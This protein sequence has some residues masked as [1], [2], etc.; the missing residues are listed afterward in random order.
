MDIS[1]DL[2]LG[3]QLCVLVDRGRSRSQPT[4]SSCGLS[5]SFGLAAVGTANPSKSL[6]HSSLGSSGPEIDSWGNKCNL[7]LPVVSPRLKPQGKCVR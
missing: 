7:F 6:S 3:G 4:S 1:Q 2:N 5:G